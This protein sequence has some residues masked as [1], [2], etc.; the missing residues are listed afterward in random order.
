[1]KSVETQPAAIRSFKP[2]VN[3]SCRVLVLGTMPGEESL[4][5]QQYYAHARNL[6]WP[7]VFRVFDTAAEPDYSKRQQFLLNRRIALWDVF[8][9]CER[10]GSL[11][12]NIRAEK[13]N[14]VA[15]LLETNPGIQYVFCNGGTAHQQFCRFVLPLL[16]RPVYHLR[17]PST[18]PANASVSYEEKLN[19]WLQIRYALENRIRYRAAVKTRA[20]LVTILSGDREVVRVCLPGHEEPFMGEYAVFS[21]NEICKKAAQQVQEYFERKRKA[22]DI[23]FTLPG[24]PFAQKVYLA[25]LGVPYGRTVSYGALAERAGNGKAARAVGQIVRKNPL[26][27]VIPCHRVI[28]SDGKSIGFMGIRGNPMQMKLLNLETK[29]G[30]IENEHHPVGH[31][32]ENLSRPSTQIQ[33][34]V[35]ALKSRG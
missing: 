24:T 20:G 7:L 26:P 1:M 15:G 23:P 31:T 6:F 29:N 28:G 34:M 5:Q 13:L 32:G 16:K 4:R 33:D 2:I 25:L 8:E 30:N 9:S 11:D 12:S 18:S 14:D 21:E 10:D 22:F 17:L 27:L 19:R 35:E 3:Q